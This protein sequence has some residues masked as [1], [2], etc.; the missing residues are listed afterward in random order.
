MIRK[1]LVFIRLPLIT[2]FWLIACNVQAHNGQNHQVQGEDERLNSALHW[3]ELSQSADGVVVNSADIATDFQSTAEALSIFSLLNSATANKTAALST[4]QKPPQSLTT[5]GLARLIIALN[6]NQQPISTQQAELLSRQGTDGGFGQFSGYDSTAF[7]TSFTLLS[8]QK[9]NAD[10]LI[11]SNVLGFLSSKQL[12]DGSFALYDDHGSVIVTAMVLKAIRPYLFT[13]NISDMLSRSIEFLYSSQNADGHWGSDW[14]TAIVLQ[15]LIPVTTDVSRYELALDFLKGN[16][17]VDGDWGQQVYT[18]SLAATVLSMLASVDVP[19]DPEKAVV[20]G[21]VTD[22]ANGSAIPNIVID[23]LGVSTETVTIQPDGSFIVSNLDPGSYVLAYSAAGYLGVSQNVTLQKGQFVNVGTIN[24]S[25]APTAA[26][27][28]GVITDSQTSE[29]VA[30][31]TISVIIAGQASSTTADTNGVYQILV[32]AGQAL[33]EVSAASYHSVTVSVD[34]VA[35]TQVQFSPSLLLS[36]EEPPSS[37]TLFGTVIDEQGQLIAGATV[38]ITDGATTTTDINGRFEFTDLTPKEVVVTVSKNGYESVS[39]GLVIP[40]RANANVGNI[41]LREQLILPSTSISGRVI[42]MVSGNGVEA[43]SVVV[44]GLSTT[45]D[46]NGF[47]QITDIPTL[48]FIVSVNAAGYL[49][50]NKQVSLAE[51]TDLNL[52]IN[53]RQADL[54][55]VNIAAVTTDKT[56]YGA[57]DSVI[58][59]TTVQN[60][61]T[62]NQGARLYVNVKDSDDN[63]VASFSGAFLPPLDPMSDLEE[64]AHYQEHLAATIEE[65]APGEQRVIKLEQWWNTLIVEPGDYSVTVQA[66]DGITSNI[67]SERSVLVT[68]EPT[69]AASLDMKLSPGYVLLNKSAEIEIF[70]E[71]F[72]RSNI[73]TLIEFDYALL[74]PSD[75][76]LTQGHEQINLTADQINHRLELLIFPHTFSASGHYQ[77][78]VSNITGVEVK[79]LITDSVFV[80]PS[81]RLRARQS[82]NPNE[83]VPLEGVTVKSNIEIEGVDGE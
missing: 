64:L 20:A 82:L 56:V 37:S 22:A 66:L 18:T 80:P 39:F 73:A 1:L 71:I 21:R 65:F 43:A 35:G 34:L 33:I 78:E 17:S 58:I 46:T 15:A 5:E 8:L 55:G 59:T 26:L 11:A 30:S 60:D 57:Y 69:R 24:L 36:S 61:T 81:I 28:K 25:I 63:E 9:I 83:V 14:E 48:E 16:Q 50:T 51:H 67:V 44:G 75:Q 2:I 32:E 45:T 3:L 13:F 31:A 53:I 77:L 27:V 79:D 70:A 12:S 62:L 38:K 54:G 40:E 19:T 7:D 72:N 10:T 4:L 74:D 76:I 68:I 23:V 49:F 29:P 42:D 47:Y 52:D 41:T 6:E